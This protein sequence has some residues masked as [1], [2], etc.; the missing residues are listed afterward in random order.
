MKKAKIWISVC[1]HFISFITFVTS[2]SEIRSPLT[3]DVDKIS[4]LKQNI[5]KDYW[6]TL[7]HIPK[8]VSGM[9]WVDLNVYHLEESL[10]QL[11]QKFGNISSN[12]DNIAI[13]IQ[14]LQDIRYNIVKKIDLGFIMEEFQCHYREVRWQTANYFDYVKDFLSAARS[15]RGDAECD[16]PPC[17]PT[18][19]AIVTER[20]SRPPEADG[21]DGLVPGCGPRTEHQYLP[22]ISDKG[23]L[24]LL[25]VP[26][27]VGLLC[28]AWKM[29]R[30]QRLAPDTD[31]EHGAQV[32]DPTADTDTS[33][34]KITLNVDTV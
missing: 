19:Q 15:R 7:H 25:I 2:V 9:C 11:A 21:C 5:P 33:E 31:A 1:I 12:R 14:T 17:P 18:T 16:S 23:L 24:L 10:K 29:C 32:K 6:I 20:L 28:L 8:E 30:R 3:D 4:I 26:L 27:A 34:E 13:Y 22:R